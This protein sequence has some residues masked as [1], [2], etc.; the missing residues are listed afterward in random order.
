MG[1]GIRM[2]PMI[3]ALMVGSVASSRLTARLGSNI[4]VAGGLL[5]T[6][7]SMLLLS[8]AGADSGY[9]LLALALIVGGLGV[10]IAMPPAVDA[11]LSALPRTQTGG[12][13]GLAGTLRQLGAAFGVAI[14]GSIL[15]SGYR[16]RLSGH[17]PGLPAQAQ[18]VVEG[19]VAAAAAVA[20]HLPAP[21]AGA[22]LRAAYDAYA[23]GMAD[24]MLVCAG[25]ALA[26]ALLVGVLLPARA[27]DT[28]WES[29]DKS[30]PADR[31]A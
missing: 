10:G 5:V 11:M 19:S 25:V 20:H 6:G 9:G 27:A 28:D 13:M 1:T 15:N 31:V 8:R 12:G 16:G 17:L 7:A 4:V 3:A 23:G 18:G 26:G 2:L 24:V 21:L 29:G 14:L 22:L 30:S